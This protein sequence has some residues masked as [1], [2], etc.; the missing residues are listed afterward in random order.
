[1]EERLDE[2]RKRERERAV[3]RE[4][5]GKEGNERER[6]RE[7]RHR[8]REGERT[9]GLVDGLEN[10]AD[11]SIKLCSRVSSSFAFTVDKP[12]DK[13]CLSIDEISPCLVDMF[14]L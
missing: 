2:E 6:V 9:V 10:F 1:M 4:G 12:V 8:G 5:V 7:G 3:W 11:H 13:Y 14:C